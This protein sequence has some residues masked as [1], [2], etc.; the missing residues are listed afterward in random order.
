[1][2]LCGHIWL[3]SIKS[4]TNDLTHLCLCRI[5]TNKHKTD[6]FQRSVLVRRPLIVWEA[7]A[8]C[9][10]DSR[11][12][13]QTFYDRAAHL[14]RFPSNV[15]SYVHSLW[16]FQVVYCNIFLSYPSF[17][18][19]HFPAWVWCRYDKIFTSESKIPH[20]MNLVSA[21]RTIDSVGIWSSDRDPGKRCPL[22]CQAVRTVN[23]VTHLHVQRLMGN[24]RGTFL[25][26]Q[27]LLQNSC[28]THT[29]ILQRHI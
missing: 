16:V 8:V 27:L 28:P 29:F 6:L 1:M 2:S 20:Q 15:F 24:K 11:R 9:S 10:K 4:S 17:S 26:D 13:R 21:H 18:L 19:A 3:C 7:K 14:N 12:H 5:N 25:T 22:G 23:W